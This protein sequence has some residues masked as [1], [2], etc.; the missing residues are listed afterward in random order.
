M[1]QK[2]S[3]LLTCIGVKATTYCLLDQQESIRT[4]ST[5]S[6][7]FAEITEGNTLVISRKIYMSTRTYLIYFPIAFL[8]MLLSRSISFLE[9]EINGLLYFLL[10]DAVFIISMVIICPVVLSVPAS[11]FF[12]IAK[13]DK[14]TRKEMKQVMGFIIW[15]KLKDD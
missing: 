10:T 4:C 15:N 3:S 12:W 6:G 11:F 2:Q 8:C 9:G 1:C 7:Y 5:V 14:F 13:G